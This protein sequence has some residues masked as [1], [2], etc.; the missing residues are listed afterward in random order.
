MTFDPGQ[1]SKTVTVAVLGDRLAEPTETFAVNLSTANA[2]IGDGQG[3]GSWL[4]VASDTVV[5]SACPGAAA[6]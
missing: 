2:F 4:Q 1:T 6:R 5:T 3:V